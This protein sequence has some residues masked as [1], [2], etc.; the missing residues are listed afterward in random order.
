VESEDPGD[1]VIAILAGLRDHKEAVRKIVAKIARLAPAEREAALGQ[2]VV[3]AGL[4]RLGRT[5]EKE[6]RKMPVYID[7]LENQI[8]GPAFKRGELTILRR[9]IEKRFGAIPDWAGERLANWPAH[10][11]EELGVRMLDARSL[12]ELLK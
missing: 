9:L 1:N 12:E 5:L 3:L 10:D 6:I 2:L 7:I 8:L 4:R 11:L